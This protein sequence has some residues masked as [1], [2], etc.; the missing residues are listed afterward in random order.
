MKVQVNK[1]LKNLDGS[2][3]VEL[4]DKK[5]V[6]IKIK[7]ILV[8]SLLVPK[9]KESGVEKVKKYELAKR[10][11]GGTVVDLKPE[12]IVLLKDSV[13]SS[14]APLIVGQVFEMLDG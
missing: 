11:H 5:E 9:E 10:I 6:A 8:N 2:P 12:E 3:I 1:K 4:K 13:G 14:Y 7:E